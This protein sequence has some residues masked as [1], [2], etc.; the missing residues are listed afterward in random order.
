MKTLIALLLTFQAFA[1]IQKAL[2]PNLSLTQMISSLEKLKASGNKDAQGLLKRLD[3]FG[4]LQKQNKFLYDSKT[5][6]LKKEKEVVAKLKKELHEVYL[7]EVQSLLGE[8]KDGDCLKIKNGSYRLQTAEKSICFPNTVCEFY[9][10]MEEKYNC[11][12]VGSTYFTEL[13]YPTCSTYRKNI[14]K[15]MFSKKGVEWIYTVMVCLQKGLV[16]E[17]EVKDNCRKKTTQAT[18]N[19][20]TQYTLDFHPSCYINSGVG[21]CSLPLRDQLNI[22]RTVGKYLTTD[23][24]K[25]AFRVVSHCFLGTD[26]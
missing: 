15:P 3:D 19:H 20:I 18:C 24:R 21:V 2:D 5:S 10:C 17:C 25:Q 22:W 13:A 12:E 9:Q 14:K 26:V 8:C 4:L 7:P 6:V 1:N 23:E 11:S 16:D